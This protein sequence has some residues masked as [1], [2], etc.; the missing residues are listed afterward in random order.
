MKF[1]RADIPGLIICEPKIL[2]DDR[3]FFTE[4]FR[5]DLFEK[6]IG[7]K[8]NFCQENMSKS[9]YGVLRGLHFQI[10]PHAQ[11]KLVSVLSGKILDVVV[12][13]R[14][15]SKQYGK[16][17]SIELDDNDNKQLF[18]PK[19]FAH[20]FI[21]LSKTARVSYKVDNYYNPESERGLN[22]NDPSLGIDWKI[23]SE[24]IVLNEKDIKYPEFKSD[25][26][27]DY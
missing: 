14:K 13:I 25:Y 6:F 23:N 2:Y 12:D 8:I 20:G 5:K 11:S 17:F 7:K 15:K 19:G 27:F 21:V 22:F 10:E 16:T 18:V 9:K 1:I 3:G 24:S 4:S 26:F